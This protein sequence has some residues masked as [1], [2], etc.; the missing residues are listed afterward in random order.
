M[1]LYVKCRIASA[2]KTGERRS[3]VLSLC[4]DL[5]ENVKLNF[6]K[7]EAFSRIK[8]V[9]YLQVSKIFNDF[10]NCINLNV[11]IVFVFILTFQA[12]LYHEIGNIVERNKRALEYRQMDEQYPTKLTNSLLTCF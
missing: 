9:I 1:L 2:P 11:F 10:S 5:L 8:D 3:Q 6:N 12:Q 7:V 4:T